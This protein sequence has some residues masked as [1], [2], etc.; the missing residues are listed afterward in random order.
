M[1]IDHARERSSLPLMVRDQRGAILVMGVFMAALLVGFLYYVKGIGEAIVYRERMQDAADTSVF[2][3]AATHA[4]GMNMEAMLNVSSAGVLAV[5]TGGRLAH[6][7][8]APAALAHITRATRGQRAGILRVQREAETQWRRLA[9]PLFSAL[10]LSNTVASAV[11]TAIPDAAQQHALDA[12]SS[13]FRPT[14]RGAFPYPRFRPLPVEDSTVNDLVLRA[15]AAVPPLAV[16]P[17]RRFSVALGFLASVPPA[18]LVR[19]AAARARATLDDRREILPFVVPKR[20][21]PAAVL[22]SESMQVRI[23]VGG[24]F[25]YALSEQGVLVAT[26]GNSERTDENQ[27]GLAA[28]G[29]LALAQAEYYYDGPGARGVAVEPELG[30]A[31]PPRPHRRPQAVR[32]V[33][34]RLLRARGHVHPRPRAG[35]G[36]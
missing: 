29:S 13:A 8:T 5:V 6:T 24:E 34:G 31:T 23:V 1:T 35:G 28:L 10:R 12:A 11:T 21:G 19:Q 14:V 36:A 18:E 15:A 25:D 7:F 26:W 2:A 33:H 3:G 32:H 20:L 30:G 22:G 16:P 17:Y 4:R 27:D 9:R